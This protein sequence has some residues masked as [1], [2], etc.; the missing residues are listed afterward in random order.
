MIKEKTTEEKM[1]DKAEARLLTITTAAR[2]STTNGNAKIDYVCFAYIVADGAVTIVGYTGTAKDVTIP[3][4]IGGKPVTEIGDWAFANNQLTSATIPNSVTTI[5]AGAFVNNRL[6][7]VT[8]GNSVTVIGDF[9]FANNQLTSASIPDS[10]ISIGNGAFHE[11]K[12][13]SVTI[14]NSVVA[15]G[16]GAFM[17][18]QLTSVTIGNS[19]TT[20]GDWAFVNNQLTSVTF[21][22]NLGTVYLREDSKAGTYISGDGG[23]TWEKQ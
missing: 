11:N 23:E 8:I 12:L 15:I 20:I 5:G 18:N 14:G 22:G 13:T 17:N 16:N 4:L 9:A 2:N 10:V 19:V 21:P 6:T 3:A 7:S 1:M